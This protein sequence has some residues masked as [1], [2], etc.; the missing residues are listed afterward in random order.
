MAWNKAP[1]KEEHL[2][3]CQAL[4]QAI[5]DWNAS[6]P[7]RERI[8]QQ[9]AA[10]MS[11]M[12][13]GAYSSYLNGRLVLNKNLAL[14]VYKAYGIPAEVY[15][16]RLAKEISDL[17]VMNGGA[18]VPTEPESSMPAKKSM[19]PPQS[20]IRSWEKLN[21]ALIRLPNTQISHMPKALEEIE[22]ERQRLA[23]VIQSLM[24]VD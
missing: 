24:Y 6:K 8:S 4:Y 17:N 5:K 7:K 1:L 9:Q 19:K 3:E 2:A 23:A 11:G 10:E 22:A 20:L 15:S 13:Q 18:S 21:T 12:T 16:P 14:L